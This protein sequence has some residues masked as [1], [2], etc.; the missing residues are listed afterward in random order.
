MNPLSFA[1]SHETEHDQ[2]T[3]EFLDSFRMYVN[4]ISRHPVLSKN[5][6]MKIAEQAFLYK[7]PTAEQKLV[8][9]NLRL[10]VKIALQHSHFRPNL[11]DLIQEGNIGL[12]RAVKKY[13][14]ARGTRFSTYAAFWIRAYILKYL[15]DDRSLVKIGTKE[16][17]RKLFY[18][19][20]KQ[21]DKLRKSGLDASAD[22][23]AETL[24]VAVEDIEDMERRLYNA[25]VSLHEPVSID[26]DSLMDTMSTGEDIEEEMG[27]RHERELVGSWLHEFKKQL[28]ERDRFILDNRIMSDDPMTLREIGDRFQVS[29]ESIRQTQ[30]RISSTL[31]K[32]LKSKAVQFGLGQFN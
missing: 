12:M 31:M 14:P 28:S 15:M 1:L 3:G 4:E 18:G 7:D 13:D 8:T 21:K 10:V 22:R 11:L 5:E 32:T 24:G 29:R 2:A 27:E 19:L 26:G 17:Q 23:L 9:A 16:T 6:E 30:C 20:N 25:D